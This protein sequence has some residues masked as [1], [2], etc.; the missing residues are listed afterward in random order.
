MKNKIMIDANASI[1][2]IVCA[3]KDYSWNPNT[4]IYER[5][6]Y[7]KRIID[8]SVTVCDEIINVIDSEKL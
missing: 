5:S 6:K 7:L 4:S 3:K 8:D 2:G 1:K